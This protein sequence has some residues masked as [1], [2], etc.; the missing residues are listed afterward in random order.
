MQQAEDPEFS[1]SW[2]LWLEIG[3][4]RR[5]VQSLLPTRR[6]IAAL[7][8]RGEAAASG[9]APPPPPPPPP[10]SAGGQI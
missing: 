9:G 6:G 10:G 2:A 1:Q 3:E 8:Q 7:G 5:Q 4:M